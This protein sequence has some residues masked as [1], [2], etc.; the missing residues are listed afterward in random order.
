ME[1]N[2][3]NLYYKSQRNSSISVLTG[4]LFFAALIIQSGLHT[5]W[6]AIM[7]ILILPVLFGIF[8]LI[9]QPTFING[10]FYNQLIN[11]VEVNNDEVILKTLSWNIL[12][13]VVYHQKTYQLSLK[14]MKIEQIHLNR[15][16]NKWWF[17]DLSYENVFIFSFVNEKRKNIKLIFIPYIIKIEKEDLKKI[18]D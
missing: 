3:D 4:V 17:K 14:S 2:F 11:E 12:G 15:L 10:K 18:I 1:S 9:Y 13:I 6:S 8:S 16:K 7:V 5:N